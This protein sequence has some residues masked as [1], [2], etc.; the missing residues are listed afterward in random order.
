MATTKSIAEI[1]PCLRYEDA[2]AAIDWLVKAFGFEKQLMV[3]GEGNTIAHA[4][5]AFGTGMIMLGSVKDD[6]YG[7]SPRALKG[8]N[9]TVYAII[10]DVDA[11]YAR[12]RAAGAEIMRDIQDEDYGGRAYTARDPE[13]N[14]WT[15]GSYRP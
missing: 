13:G 15:F 7:Q 5:L 3:A 2:P 1:I 12:A 9:Q 6:P 11:H 8:V 4:Q 14:I 10:D